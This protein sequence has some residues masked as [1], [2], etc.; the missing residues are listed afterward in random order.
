MD[1]T[2]STAIFT[3]HLVSIVLRSVIQTPYVVGGDKFIQVSEVNA[4]GT[5]ASHCE[6]ISLTFLFLID[7]TV[8]NSSTRKKKQILWRR[9]SVAKREQ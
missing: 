9:K 2:A 6:I 3:I 5:I 7:K 4:V 8:W 1:S